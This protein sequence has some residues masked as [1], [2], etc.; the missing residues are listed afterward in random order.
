MLSA[1]IDIGYHPVLLDRTDAA[2]DRLVQLAGIVVCEFHLTAICISSCVD[3][4]IIAWF[5]Y[6]RL[7]INGYWAVMGGKVWAKTYFF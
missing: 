5:V 4:V 6:H 3:T 1:D 7:I 2:A